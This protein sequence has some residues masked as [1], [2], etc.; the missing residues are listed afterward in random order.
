MKK[1][2]RE[3]IIEI[4]SKFPDAFPIV[5]G[6]ALSTRGV[7]K[8]IGSHLNIPRK[9]K[10]NKMPCENGDHRWEIWITQHGKLSQRGMSS[11]LNL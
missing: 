5:K 3:I 10:R 11:I 8:P 7:V 2:N 9:K 4:R 1:Y 6:Y